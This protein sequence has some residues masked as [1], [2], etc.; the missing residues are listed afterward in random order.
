DRLIGLELNTHGV[1]RLHNNLIMCYNILF[2]LVDLNFTDFFAFS[3]AVV[4]RGHQY[5]LYKTRSGVFRKKF[6]GGLT[7]RA[8]ASLKKFV[9]MTDA[10]R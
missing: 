2:G 7:W 3:P 10:R 5:K 9:C 4:T 6:R 1:R 8:L